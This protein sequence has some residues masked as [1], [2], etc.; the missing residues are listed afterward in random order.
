MANDLISQKNGSALY[1]RM[2]SA[3]AHCYKVDD[4][5]DIA[6]QAAA[7]SAYY[8]QIR[9]DESVRKFLAVKMRAWRRIGEICKQIDQTD[10]AT[11]T[12]YYVKIG[13]KYPEI[14]VSQISNALRLADVPLDFFESALNSTST[15]SV[16]GII[17]GYEG[18]VHRLWEQSPEG[19]AE[20]A[21]HRER[22]AEQEKWN[23]EQS[24]RAKEEAAEKEL[25]TR[26][27]LALQNEIWTEF[28]TAGQEVGYTMDRRDR[29][30]MKS[31]V[32]LLN[33]SLHSVLRQ[34]AFDKHMT[35]QAVLRSGLEAWLLYN[36]Y[37]KAEQSDRKR[38]SA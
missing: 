16:S 21:R 32:L 12:A 38:K 13:R 25:D 37:D 24:K 17:Y 8:K 26:H 15:A 3:I 5:K 34:A 4:C 35:M 36:C 33:E 6:D 18:H 19:Q 11:K 10:C 14:S 2:S 28:V 7:I 20:I 30:T 31:V 22:Y 9:D 23:A 1:A 29:K 27:Q